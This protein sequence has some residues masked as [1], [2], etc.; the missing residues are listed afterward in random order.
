MSSNTKLVSAV[1]CG[2]TITKVGPPFLGI[3]LIELRVES[4]QYTLFWSTLISD[5]D[6]RPVTN[7]AE[8]WGTHVLP[9]QISPA[10]HARPQAPQLDASAV[11]TEHVVP[12][13]VQPGKQATTHFESMHTAEPFVAGAHMLPQVPQ[14]RVYD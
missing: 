2:G 13:A 5:G 3:P 4:D 1:D 6:A 14:P 7:H 11:V 9:V 10:A 8:L 12:Q